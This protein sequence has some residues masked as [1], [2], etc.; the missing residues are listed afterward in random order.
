MK[1]G[2]SISGGMHAA[3]IIA[4]LVGFDWF[5]DREDAPFTVTEIEMIDGAVFDAVVSTAPVVKSDGPADL[6]EPNENNDKAADVARP[7]D[8]TEAIAAPV[9]TQAPTPE[10]RPERPVINFAPPPTDVPTEAPAP[11]IAEI[12]SPDPLDRQA[13]VPESPPS[14]EPVQPLASLV[15]PS[16]A[17][18]PA[19]PPPPE[20]EPEPQK[21]EQTPPQAPE[22]TATEEKKPEPL[23][24]QKPDET[25]LAEAQPEAPEGA[26]PREAKLPVARPAD[27]AAAARAASKPEP[28][29]QTAEKTEEEP[30]KAKPAGGSQSEF[31]AKLTRGERDALRL[32]IKKYYVY[33]GDRSDRDL[34]VVI[35]VEID[36]AGQIVGKPEER[37]AEGGTKAAQQALFRAGRR[38]LIQAANAGEFKRLPPDKYERWKVLNFRF[39]V[40]DI[41]NLS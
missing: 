33:N 6:T 10:A 26:A 4:A 28:A 15:A 36:R 11:S 8:Q 7:D 38:A 31:A 35:R 3:L 19:P 39:S 13:A 23:P 27:K 12:P 2:A 9:L 18:A 16:P 29:Q 25:S 32:G 1:T 34:R 22:E 5:T 37:S 41:G 14:T 40:D 21:A 17:E 30:A 24:E 20:P